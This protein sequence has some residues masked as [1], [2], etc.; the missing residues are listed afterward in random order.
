MNIFVNG[1]E[2]YKFKV[3]VSEI[4][5]APL[6]LCEVS[7]VFSVEIWKIL[8]YMDMSRTFETILILLMLMMLFVIIYVII[9][10]KWL[11]KKQDIK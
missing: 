6:G 3:N 4:N 5:T 7:K 8:D 9:Y 1:V 10:D 11:M 2:I